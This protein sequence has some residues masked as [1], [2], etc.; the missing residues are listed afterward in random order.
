MNRIITILVTIFILLLLYIWISHVWG[1]DDARHPRQ[2]VDAKDNQLSDDLMADADST[3]VTSDSNYV[4]EEPVNTD[5]FATERKIEDEAKA[6]AKAKEEVKTEPVKSEPVAEKKTLS[7]KATETKTEPKKVSTTPTL[8]A[9]PASTPSKTESKPAASLSSTEG[10]HLVIAG[11]F[12]QK[13]NAEQRV[14]E[15]KKAGFPEAE[16]VN[17]DL[18]EYH[19]VCVGRFSDVNEARRLVKK[20]KDYHKID[21][22]VRIGS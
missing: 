13:V 10:Q 20:L 4:A 9:K 7:T 19:T 2:I 18:S 8:T 6:E 16:V 1:G 12:T 14:H 17:F 11:N 21:A 15:L 5:E 3:Y 22:Y